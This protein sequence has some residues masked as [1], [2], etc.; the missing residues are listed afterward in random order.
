MALTHRCVAVKGLSAT[1]WFRQHGRHDVRPACSRVP[2][3]ES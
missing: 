1:K 3:T 2:Q